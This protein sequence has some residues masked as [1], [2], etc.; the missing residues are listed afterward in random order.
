MYLSNYLTTRSLGKKARLVMLSSFHG[1]NTPIVAN[2]KIKLTSLSEEPEGVST[3]TST[4][5]QEPAGH[6][7]QGAIGVSELPLDGLRPG[8]TTVQ[9]GLSLHPIL[10]PRSLNGCWS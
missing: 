5:R 2:F 6:T 1:V 4:S 8:E 3:V 7:F 9:F 10:C